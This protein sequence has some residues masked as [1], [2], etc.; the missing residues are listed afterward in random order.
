MCMPYCWYDR[1]LTIFDDCLGR[2]CVTPKTGSCTCHK[3]VDTSGLAKSAVTTQLLIYL[4]M[5]LFLI[6][7]NL[8]VRMQLHH[9]FSFSIL[10]AKRVYEWSDITPTETHLCFSSDRIPGTRRKYAK[11]TYNSTARKCNLLSILLLRAKHW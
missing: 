2:R 4:D 10:A 9:G 3:S 8:A 1:C 5:S 7:A 11:S 6:H